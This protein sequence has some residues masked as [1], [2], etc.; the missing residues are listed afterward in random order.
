MGPARSDPGTPQLTKL[1]PIG[2]T[3]AGLS[4]AGFLDRVVANLT[5]VERLMLH[6]R[7]ISPVG[8]AARLAGP[9]NLAD[10]ECVEVTNLRAVMLVVEEV[11]GMTE[12]SRSLRKVTLCRR[13]CAEWLKEERL[14]TERAAPAKSVELVRARC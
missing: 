10:S 1:A 11:D 6:A 8:M 14:A 9:S 7:A 3:S 2:R 4:R 12:R 5:A 13:A